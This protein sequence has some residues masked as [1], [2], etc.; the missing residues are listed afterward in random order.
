LDEREF[1]PGF[2]WGSAGAAHQ[3]EGGNDNC[4]WWVHEH[5]PETN[6]AEP[7]GNACDSYNRFAEDWQLL[8]SSGQNSVRFSVEWARIEPAPGEFSHQAL[9]H[10]REVIGTAR[11]LGL[12]TFVTLHHFTNPIWF[13]EGGAWEKDDSVNVFRR[14]AERVSQTLGDLLEVVNTIN[15]PQI[16]ASLGYVLGY[17][18][19]RKSDLALGHRVTANLIKSHA[20]AVEAVRAKT[21]AKVG[22]A[23]SMTD[24]VAADETQ[25]AKQ[26]RDMTHWSMAGVYLEALS[27]GRI[28]G[29]IVPDEKVD[30][31]AGTDDFVGVQYYTKVVVDPSLL[32]APS[33]PSAPEPR[34]TDSRSEERVTQMGW[35]WH[36]EGLGKVIDEAAALGLPVYVTENGIATDDDKERI[37]YV[38]LHLEQVRAAIDR[39]ADVRGYFYW[40]SLDNFEWNHGYR[41]KFGL[42]A[43]D[44]KTFER[45]PKPSLAWY[46]DVAKRNAVR[47]WKKL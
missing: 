14:Y 3:T 22:V 2:L 21:S 20:A 46:G 9:D 30:A 16:V 12:T 17:F 7:S 43:C 1:P 47:G 35:V 19:P 32:A 10:Y 18:P 42:I 6:A 40:S 8:A 28:T 15:E 44:R 4:D 27:S 36:P 34:L 45:R 39:G 5:A 23:L 29:L 26:F 33:A 38:T 13:A 24:F 25:E 37:E 11:D 31:I 41:P